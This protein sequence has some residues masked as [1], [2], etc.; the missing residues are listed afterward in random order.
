[1]Y[2]AHRNRQVTELTQL[3]SRSLTA[4]KNPK[5]NDD[6]RMRHLSA[7]IIEA[8]DLGICLFSLPTGFEFRWSRNE[9]NKIEIAPALVKVTDE[10]GHKLAESQVVVTATTSRQKF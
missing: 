4:W 10:R 1:M 7:I 8:V 5:Y 9:E 3:F 2:I 6:E